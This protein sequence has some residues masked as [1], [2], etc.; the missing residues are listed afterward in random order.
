M[1]TTIRSLTLAAILIGTV[2]GATTAAAQPN[3]RRV[4]VEHRQVEPLRERQALVRERA[5]LIRERALERSIE[6]RVNARV[7][8]RIDAAVGPR[9]NGRVMRERMVQRRVMARRAAMREQVRNMT[10]EQRT[11]L[12]ANREAF[13]VQ[14]EAIGGQL[15]AGTITREQARERI[16]AW[17]EQHPNGLRRPPRGPG[18]EF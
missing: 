4:I 17:R 3:R 15:R 18:G 6:R 8:D 2:A 16:R 11:A 14:R 5:T 10:P 9:G 13:R 1:R 12:R 7:N